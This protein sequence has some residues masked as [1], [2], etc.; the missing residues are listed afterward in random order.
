MHNTDFEE[1]FLD[2]DSFLEGDA[3]QSEERCGCDDDR[4]LL[5]DD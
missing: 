3:A 2:D 1:D 5:E 4:D